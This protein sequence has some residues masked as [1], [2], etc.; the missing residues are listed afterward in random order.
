MYKMIVSDLDET[1]VPQTGNVSQFTIDTLQQLKESGVIIAFAT[2]RDYKSA[3][4]IIEQIGIHGIHGFSN[5]SDIVSY[6]SE[7]Y[8]QQEFVSNDN[9]VKLIE[10]CHKYQLN[11]EI[12]TEDQVYTTIQNDITVSQEKYLKRKFLDDLLWYGQ[13]VIK[14]QIVMKGDNTKLPSHDILFDVANALMMNLN[15]NYAESINTHFFNFGSLRSD[16]LF[17]VQWLCDYYHIRLDQVIAFGDSQNDTNMIQNVGY[18]IA[19]KN[20]ISEVQSVASYVLPHSVDKDG[21]VQ[22]LRDKQSVLFG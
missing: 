19:V 18:G 14:V 15:V 8:L 3:K 12:Y 9:V 2:G 11:G 17:F 10:I 16:K 21:V 6:P 5:G 13:P 4:P 7:T 1:L 22:F 20:A